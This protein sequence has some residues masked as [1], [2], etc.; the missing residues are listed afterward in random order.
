MHAQTPTPRTAG[1]IESWLREN[2]ARLG[3]ISPDDVDS[4]TP[5][6]DFGLESLMLFALAGDLANWLA[7]DIATTLLWEYPTIAE[8]A[9]HLESAP[10]TPALALPAP[11]PAPHNRRCAL[12]TLQPHGGQPPLYLVHDVSGALW[13]YRRLV[14]HLGQ[15]RPIYAFQLAAEMAA[16]ND[17][18]PNVPDIKTLAASYVEELVA[19]ARGPYLLGGYSV[20]GAIAFEMARQLEARGE[21]VARLILFDTYFPPLARRRSRFWRRTRWRIATASGLS[22][23]EQWNYLRDYARQQAE[24]LGLKTSATPIL[25]PQKLRAELLTSQVAA[26]LNR[27]Q[28]KYRPREYGG[29]I[30]YLRARTQLSMAHDVR[31]WKTVARGGVERHTVNGTHGTMF[32]EPNVQTLAQTLQQLLPHEADQLGQPATSPCPPT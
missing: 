31:A 21:S 26:Q 6:T 22:R 16:E 8:I 4:H 5:I 30:L 3:Q 23:R 27:A 7:H 28:R 17:A 11:A 20:G 19:H 1:A 25:T 24:K 32:Q 15:E 10:A 2:I 12:V 18:V 13:S 14:R 29:R 9:A